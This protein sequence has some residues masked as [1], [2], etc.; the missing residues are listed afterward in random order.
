MH[1]GRVELALDYDVRLGESLLQV[2]ALVLDVESDVRRGV[3]GLVRVVEVGRI[4]GV[5]VVEQYGR[6]LGHALG[7]RGHR[8]QHL[9]VDLDQPERLLGDVRVGRRDAGHRMA[10][11]QGLLPGE[12]GVALSL[13]I[14]VAQRA[15]VER[16]AGV[17]LRQVRRRHGRHDAGE[18]VL[19]LAGHLLVAVVA[20]G[21]CA[22]HVEGLV[23][24]NDV[25]LV[26]CR[27]VPTSYIFPAASIIARTI[28]S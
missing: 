3:G 8:G 23:R 2:A 27:H 5:Q 19:R 20:H 11:V 10:P 28:L 16:V 1:G 18:P 24:E 4:L 12:D 9:V 15:V 6:A 25:S 22:H 21:P 17:A 7:G 14:R 13:Q 26:G